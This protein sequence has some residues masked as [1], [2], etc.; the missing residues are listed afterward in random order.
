M[1]ETYLDLMKWESSDEDYGHVK[2]LICYLQGKDTFKKCKN[3]EGKLHIPFLH[4]NLTNQIK[5]VFG[6]T[7][8]FN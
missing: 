4:Q 8:L 1:I 5:D 6:C 7:N 2:Q 3:Y